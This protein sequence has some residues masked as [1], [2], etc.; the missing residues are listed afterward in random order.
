MMFASRATRWASV[1]LL[2]VSWSHAQTQPPRLG[3]SFS[4]LDVKQQGLMRRWAEEYKAI[5]HREINV[6]EV[7]DKLPLSARTTFQAVTHAL[8]NSRLTSKDGRPM[9]TALD[10]VDVVERVAGQVPNARGDHQFRVYVYLKPGALNKL[11]AAKE[12]EREHDNTVYHV[13]YP[14]N[15]RQIGGVP[16]IQVSI[17]RTGKRADID[18][19]YRSSA[20]VKA[21]FSGHLTSA[22]SDVRAGGNGTT[23]NRRWNG[24]PDWWHDLMSV[25]VQ[26]APKIETTEI[27][28]AARETDLA[29]APLPDAIHGY[30]S[31]WLIERRPEQLLPL[32]SIKAYPCIAEFGGDSRPDSKMALLRILRRLEERSAALGPLKTL[33]GVVTP[34]SYPLPDSVPVSHAHQDL[35]SVRQVPDDVGWALDCRIRYKLQLAESIPRPSHQLNG[36]YVV[37]MRIRDPKEPESFLVQTWKQEHGEW[38]IVAFEIKRK[39]ITPPQD[40]LAAFDRPPAKS[41]LPAQFAT[42]A[43]ELLE[44]WL[45]K[46][47]PSA[48]TQY[49]LASA[50]LCGERSETGPDQAVRTFLDQIAQNAYP[51]KQLEGVISSVEVDH[52]EIKPLRHANPS[53]FFVGELSGDLLRTRSCASTATSGNVPGARMVTAFR[54]VQPGGEEGG[55]VTL[56]WQTY[57]DRWRVFAYGVSTD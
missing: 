41:S 10:L 37:S 30:L 7:Y 39:A 29:K 34:V 53:A 14:I 51:D 50:R 3:G 26:S 16:S 36:T 52:H 19:D 48:A 44:L 31:E 22:N 11:Y 13:G 2:F 33:E 8:M 12:F 54:L 25:F 46:K 5:I 20:G 27:P 21:L 1:L 32:F 38:R 49:F 56:Y 55:V 45:I 28:V 15:F 40:L 43:R 4:E 42:S 17:A 47:D 18:V 9:G 35:F 24:L 6:E 57:Q 23:H